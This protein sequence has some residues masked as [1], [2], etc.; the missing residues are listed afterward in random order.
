VTVLATDGTPGLELRPRDSGTWIE[1]PHIPG[2]VICNIGDCLMRWSNDIYV[3]TPHRVRAP[4]SERFSVAF[5]MD[6]NPE[7]VVE[8]LPGCTGPGRPPKYRPVTAAAYLRERLDATY[9]H[10]RELKGG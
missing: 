5:F 6:P 4:S 10:R 2:A 9:A 3:S 1:V 7:A 8:A